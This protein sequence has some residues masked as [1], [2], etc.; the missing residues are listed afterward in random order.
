MGIYL[1]NMKK[2]KDCMSCAFHHMVGQYHYCWAFKHHTYMDN[3]WDINKKCP[4]IEIKSHG[5]LIDADEILMK[6][7]YIGIIDAYKI[8]IAP[9]IIEAEDS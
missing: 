3:N 2:P 7:E 8:A 4:L 9:T 5:R 6:N 1:K